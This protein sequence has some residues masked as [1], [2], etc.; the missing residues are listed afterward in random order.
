ME[1]PHA[2]F[3]R[4]WEWAALSE[5]AADRSSGA[6]LGI[7]AGR[8][9]Q[10]KTLLLQELCA[11]TGG[12]YFAATEATEAES[13]RLVAHAHAQ[14]TGLPVPLALSSWEQ[15]CDALLALGAGSDIGVP[16]VLDEFPYLCRASPALPSIIQKALGPRRSERT[17]SRSRLI[18]CGSALTFM[19][20]LLSGAAPLRGRAGLDLTVPTFDPRTA[21]AFWNIDDWPLA[22]RVH[23]VVGDTP[24]YRREYVRGDTPVDASDFDAWVCRTVLNPASPLHKEARYLLAEEAD[25][26][27]PALYHS[28]LAAVADGHST[29]GA[30]ARYVG[31][32]DDRLRHPITVLEDAGLIVREQD[33]LRRAR[34]RYRIAEPLI[35]FYHAVI[36]PERSRLQRPEAAA[37]VWSD[38]QERFASNVLGPNFEQLCRWWTATHASPHTLGGQPTRVGSGVIN[39]ARQKARHELDVVATDS[40]GRILA[41]GEAKVGTVMNEGQL[42]RLERIRDLLVQTGHDAGDARLLCCSARGFT[43]PLQ[44]AAT[45]GRATLVDLARIYTGT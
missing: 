45:T 31:R 36:R 10:G 30:I 19:G 21:A 40:S 23:A 29:R 1:K 24:A 32:P 22:F 11:A 34:S 14:H 7:V 37:A 44:Q 5:F 16:V 2:V 20:G 35:T 9:R 17:G 4:D 27:D 6:T 42:S 28:V 3:D 18:L 8:R 26:R 15:A 25:I 39:D 38:S 12:F 13:L 43:P 41:I 33:A